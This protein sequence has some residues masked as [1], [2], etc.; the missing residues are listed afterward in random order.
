MNDT[1]ESTRPDKSR[2]A[3][4]SPWRIA[5]WLCLGLIAVSVIACVAMA[6]ERSRGLTG[7]TVTALNPVAEPR[8]H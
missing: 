4:W 6:A 5:M 2:P 8:D 1:Q 3:G 7:I